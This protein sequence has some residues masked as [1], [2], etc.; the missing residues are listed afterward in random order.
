MITILIFIIILFLYFHLVA[1]FKKSEDLEI[2][3]MDFVNNENLQDIC[4]IKQ[5]VLF[6]FQ[7]MSELFETNIILDA[8]TITNVKVK[9][10]NDIN[11][12]NY[13]T[14]SLQSAKRLMDTDSKSRFYS[15][16]NDELIENIDNKKI[17]LLNKYF[18]PTFTVNTKYDIMFG[19]KNAYTS[20]RY[21]TNYRQF[22]CVNSGKIHVKMT[23]WKS[24]KYLHPE[25]DYFHYEFRSPIDVWNPQPKYLNEMDKIKF[26]EFDVNAGHVLY[27]PPYW[28]YSIKYSS[29]E[30]NTIIGITYNSAMNYIANIPNYIMYLF[31]QQNTNK[32]IV[33]VLNAEKPMDC[34]IDIDKEKNK[35]NSIVEHNEQ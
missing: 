31:E 26:L 15:E 27:I 25:K 32:K 9:D 20:I 8:D 28:F 35:D 18:Q 13:I 14:L 24:R 17:N 21:H 12:G 4:E 10:V 6:E 22:I 33:K 34:S 2:Y 29:N 7:H 11:T 23:P 3:E 1:Q 5:P 16:N 19:S 30:E